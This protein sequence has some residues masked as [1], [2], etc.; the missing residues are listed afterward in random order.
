MLM[1]AAEGMVDDPAG[2]DPEIIEY[3]H[4]L[5]AGISTMSGEGGRMRIGRPGSAA[6]LDALNG[7]ARSLLERFAAQSPS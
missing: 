6:G 5:I 3:V 4:S 1:D 7:R 2:Q